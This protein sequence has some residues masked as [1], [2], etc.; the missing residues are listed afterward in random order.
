MCL[1][2][3]VNFIIL[4]VREETARQAMCRAVGLGRGEAGVPALCP[5]SPFLSSA[6]PLSS[7]QSSC[8]S[9]TLLPSLL[10]SGSYSHS[11]VQ[12]GGRSTWSKPALCGPGMP[13]SFSVPPCF[14]L[15][16]NEWGS[17]PHGNA[18]II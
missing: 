14:H 10:R 4:E 1:C 18:V 13:G 3:R 15:C 17:L 7:A 12:A 5:P 9:A 11:G 16:R 8:P 2:L 6:I